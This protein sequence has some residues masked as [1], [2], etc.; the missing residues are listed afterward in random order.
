MKYLKQS[1]VAWVL[2]IASSFSVAA[3]NQVEWIRI[4][5]VTLSPSSQK[6]RVTLNQVVSRREFSHIKLTCIQGDVDIKSLD[7]EMSSGEKRSYQ[8]FNILTQGVST[9]PLALPGSRVSQLSR[10]NV[11]YTNWGAKTLGSFASDKT[12]K[13]EIWGQKI[14]PATNQ[15]S[16]QNQQN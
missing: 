16:D 9:R 10:F 6:M 8:T 1:V 13:L 7:L 4:D 5:T 15:A 12:T 2:L 3:A 14:V 11:S